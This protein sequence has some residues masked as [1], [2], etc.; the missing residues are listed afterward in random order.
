MTSPQADSP[1][2][3]PDHHLVRA[4]RRRSRPVAE[5]GSAPGIAA[6]FEHGRHSLVEKLRTLQLEDWLRPATHTAHAR[7]SIFLMCRHIALHDGLHAYRIEES[8][9]GSHWPTER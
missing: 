1:G 7:Y 5:D 4:G 8:A 3:P 6:A 2:G 9:L